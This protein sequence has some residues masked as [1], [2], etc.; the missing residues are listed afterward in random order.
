MKFTFSNGSEFSVWRSHN[1]DE[2][3]FDFSQKGK[4]IVSNCPMEEA[5][6]L[7]MAGIEIPQELLEKYIGDDKN[8][9]L[10]NVD[11]TPEDPRQVKLTDITE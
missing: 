2:C 10:K 3:K 11:L 1:C 9:K 7:N 6:A 5:I 8:C 4:E